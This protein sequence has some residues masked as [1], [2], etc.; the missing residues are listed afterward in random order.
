MDSM[1]STTSVNSTKS[2]CVPVIAPPPAEMCVSMPAP[3]KI[4]C[5]PITIPS[6]VKS[7]SLDSLI[8]FNEDFGPPATIQQHPSSAGE[9]QATFSQVDG[10]NWAV[11][12]SVSD[13]SVTQKTNSSSLGSD[14]SLLLVPENISTFNNAPTL[15]NVGGGGVDPYPKTSDQF[16][17][18]QE[19][20][21]TLFASADDHTS[22]QFPASQENISTLFAAAV[23][24]TIDVSPPSQ[25]MHFYLLT[26][27]KNGIIQ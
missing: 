1:G 5:V 7:A 19:N 23:D 17:A 27:I 14:L 13:Q 26:L 20:M 16:P 4:K 3:D 24:H 2:K 9:T 10:G 25:A 22:D 11:F 6:E 8:D 15:P 21:S 12:D 18:S